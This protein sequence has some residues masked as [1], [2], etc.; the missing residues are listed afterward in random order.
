MFYEYSF[1][2]IDPN[3][4]E[5]LTPNRYLKRASYAALSCTETEERNLCLLSKWQAAQ[6]LTD[7]I[8]K[9]IG[10]GIFTNH[11]ETVKIETATEGNFNK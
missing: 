10:T 2:S 8:W 5:A 7:I 6:M 3:G 9:K 4:P 1:I 11:I